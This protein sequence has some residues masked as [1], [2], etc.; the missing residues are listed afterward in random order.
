M[1]KLAGVVE[2]ITYRNIENNYTVL[3]LEAKQRPKKLI[4]VTG[5]FPSINVGETIELEGEWINHPQ[6]GFQFNTKEYNTVYPASIDGIVKF[7]G[8]GIIKGIGP[9]TAKSIVNHFKLKTLDIIEDD[10]EKLSE[11]DGI[12]EKRIEMIRSGWEEHKAIK[13]VMIFLASHNI[14][15]GHAIKIFNKFGIY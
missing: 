1:E 10:I 2:I 9:V 4:T 8:S 7:L 3:K 11:V 13:D 5:Y 15:T 14:S 6:Y 12:G